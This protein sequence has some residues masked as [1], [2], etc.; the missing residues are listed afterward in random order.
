[1]S[2][3][4]SSI[5]RR[6]LSLV[7]VLL[8][9]ATIAA[10]PEV[11]LGCEVIRPVSKVDML[12]NTISALSTGARRRAVRVP[13][14]LIE[15][16]V[17]EVYGPQFLHEAG[18]AEVAK[19]LVQH[20]ID[21]TNLALSD[22]GLGDVRLRLR[23]V[24][25]SQNYDRFPMGHPG[26]EI[27]QDREHYGA[28]LL[29]FVV[30]EMPFGFGGAAC[31]PPAYGPGC[32]LHWVQ[33]INLIEYPLAYV[34][35]IG[36]NLG[37]DHDAPN[38]LPRDIDPHP[39]ARAH[40]VP[41]QWRT[42]MSYGDPCLA[43][44]VLLFSNPMRMFRGLSTGV[45]DEADNARG[46]QLSAPLVRD[47]YPATQN[48]GPRCEFNIT[49]DGTEVPLAGTTR[50]VLV[51]RMR[52][53]CEPAVAS[54]DE[55]VRIEIAPN[56]TAERLEAQVTYLSNDEPLS[57]RGHFVVG[58]QPVSI[59][60][61][62]AAACLLSNGS[63]DHDV[64]GWTVNPFQGKQGAISWSPIDVG[65]EPGSGS[66]M[67]TVT[68]GQFGVRRCVAVEPSS[69]YILRSSVFIPPGQKVDAADLPVLQMVS[70]FDTP[71]CS[72]P[73]SGG[74]SFIKSITT[75]WLQTDARFDTFANTRSAKI[76]LNVNV[77]PGPFTT[78]YDDV[79]LC[80]IGSSN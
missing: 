26:P 62:G 6:G 13:S 49:F 8:V 18:S 10:Q 30:G 72:G 68:G 34:H 36:H 64:S 29:G 47:Y 80:R 44:A 25:F 75:N 52:G 70:V 7:A 24:R 3:L 42:L 58:E 31:R 1:M 4:K 50:T 35:E 45:T 43:N 12:R 5:L 65:N 48:S 40:C 17:M 79:H 77:A 33:S 74:G 14:G 56:S 57:R 27:V 39:F 37:A 69:R 51:E 71:D 22:S 60:Q 19:A 76:S 15:I 63:F 78:H 20:Q 66:A 16:D 32:G 11:P 67:L 53:D 38:A 21:R 41:G 23:H 46:V 2:F 59:E 28:D 73:D 55:W 9:S 54:L 61:S